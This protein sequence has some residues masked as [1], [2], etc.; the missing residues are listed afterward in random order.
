MTKLDIY[1]GQSAVDRPD[2]V[3][4]VFYQKQQALLQKIRKGYFGAVAGLVYTIEYQKHGLPHMHLLIFLEEQDKIRTTKQIDAFISAQIPDVNIH[5]QLYAA[6]SKF[7]IHD[8]SPQRCVENGR[9]KKYFPKP[10][11]AQTVMKDDGYPEY[12]RP[13]NGRTVEKNDTTYTN[14]HV[15]PH[16]RELIVEFDCHINLEVCASIKSIK[17]VHKY[18][19]KGPDRATLQTQGHDEIKAYLDSR[20]ISSVEACWRLFEFPMHLE[21]PSVYRLVVHLENQQN[22][23]YNDGDD[24][25]A[26]L[27]AAAAKDTQLTGWFKA[28][29]DPACIAAGGHDCLYQDFPKKFVWGKV[30][31]N[32]QSV[33]KWKPRQRGKAIGR[34]YSISPSAGESFY[35]RLLLTE[36]KGKWLSLLIIMV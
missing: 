1:V 22:I 15:V 12:A 32:R 8:C 31:V 6:V 5:P 25:Q 26:V 18:I 23:T 21:W 35:L 27:E 7:M 14:E 34:M 30:K 3:A 29:S 33:W 24:P 11:C 10:F 13:N 20:Y 2:L 17:Y 28:N 19:Y 16:P 9:C 36:V 4:R